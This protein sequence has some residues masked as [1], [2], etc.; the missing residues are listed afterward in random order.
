M[1]RSYVLRNTT[2]AKLA[3]AKR[4]AAKV[5]RLNKRTEPKAK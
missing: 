4:K 2:A 3:K 5:S 1:P